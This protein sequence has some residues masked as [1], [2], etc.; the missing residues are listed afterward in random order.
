MLT[1]SGTTTSK[2]LP[3]IGRNFDDMGE[4]KALAN[5]HTFLLAI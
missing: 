1:P 4:E 2:E 3:E 5:E